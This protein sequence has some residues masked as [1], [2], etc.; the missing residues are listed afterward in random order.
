M[1]LPRLMRNG[2]PLNRPMKKFSRF[3]SIEDL[4]QLRALINHDASSPWPTPEQGVL[5]KNILV[6]ASSPATAAEAASW[7]GL[8]DRVSLVS[9]K[10]SQD[11]FNFTIVL[12]AD[13]DPDQDLISILFPISLSVI[14]CKCGE[15]VSWETPRGTREMRIVSISKAEKMLA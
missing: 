1:P 5:L 7:I 11:Y 2:T 9:P 10:D 12:P 4:Q 3:L 15:N 13:A 6:E 14:G 8:G